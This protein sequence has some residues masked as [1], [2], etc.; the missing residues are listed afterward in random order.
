[1]F[2]SSESGP[3]PTSSTLNLP[4]SFHAHLDIPSGLFQ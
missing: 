2:N 4:F 3:D 1:M